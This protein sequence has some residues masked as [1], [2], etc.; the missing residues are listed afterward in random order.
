[1]GQEKDKTEQDASFCQ[2]FS[3]FNIND[4]SDVAVYQPIINQLISDLSVNILRSTAGFHDNAKN[5]HYHFHAILDSDYNQLNSKYTTQYHKNKIIN[6]KGLKDKSRDISI[7]IQRPYTTPLLPDLDTAVHRFLRYPL[8]ER[9]PI[10]ELCTDC[11]DT[12]TGMINCSDSEYQFALEQKLKTENKELIKITKYKEIENHLKE[13][14]LE[15][16]SSEI[17]RIYYETNKYICQHDSIPPTDNVLETFS[18]RYINNNASEEYLQSKFKKMA[19]RHQIKTNTND[20]SP[21]QFGEYL[22]KKL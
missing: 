18:Q 19:Y 12:I 11:S 3:R 13:L 2:L 7:K 17:W 10:M 22:M 5:K 15:I 1:M 21:Q 4:A 9:K 16:E 14:N 20:L 6:K 8:K